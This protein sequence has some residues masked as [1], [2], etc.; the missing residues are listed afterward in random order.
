MNS[1]QV[2]FL[3][4]RRRPLLWLVGAFTAYSLAGFLLAPVI[5]KHQ[6]VKH[7]SA[8]LKRPVAIEQ[9]RVNPWTLSVTI[10]GLNVAA[11]D[12]AEFAGWE[13]F[14]ANF[15]PLTSL[16][17]LTW[18]LDEI[19]LVHPRARIYREADGTFNIADLVP[20]P[21][22]TAAPAT[23]S[24]PPPVA[25]A[26]LRVERGEFTFADKARSVPFSTTFGPTTFELIGFTTRPNRSGAYTFEAATEAGERFAWQGNLTFEPLGSTGRVAITDLRLP[27]YAAFH[28]DLHQLDLLDGRLG[29]EVAYEVG[30]A[31]S[32]PVARLTNGRVTLAD[33]K[34]A[35]R[36]TT[37]ALA[38]IPL[39]ELAGLAAIP[40]ARRK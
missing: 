40:L 20:P 33:L 23:P 21:A 16:F 10:R 34:L 35:A 6:L 37:A 22:A 17:R 8:A 15:A 19:R 18:S 28:R 36:G 1:P 29:V 7:G 39:V 25:I 3:R 11:H 30:L 24:R 32:A 31:G 12:G 26:R 5:L 27:K 2:P 4:R 38:S 9:V 13:E 14:H